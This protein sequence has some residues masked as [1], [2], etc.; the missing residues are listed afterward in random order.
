MTIETIAINELSADPGNVRTHGEAQIQKLV[1]SLRRWGQT[2]PLLVDANN[3]VRVGNA[4]LEAMKRLG[5][6]TANVIRLDLS[7][8]EWV[9]L[10]IADNKLH[11]DSE[12]DQQALSNVLAA[13]KTEDADLAEAAGFSPEELATLLGGSPESP[14]APEDFPSYDEKIKCDFRCPKCA[15]EWSGSPGGQD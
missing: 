8:S 10:S 7:P 4:R 12:F 6:E 15:Y 9:A 3:V 11:D 1:A 5:W 2:L 13:L 14:D